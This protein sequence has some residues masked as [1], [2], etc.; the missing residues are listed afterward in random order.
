MAPA[1][2][3]ALADTPEEVG[4]K[5]E[6]GEP[7]PCG[8]IPLPLLVPGLW[9]V[10][11][12]AKYNGEEAPVAGKVVK[13][14]VEGPVTELILCPTGT[15][16]EAL[17]KYLTSVPGAQLRGHLC[18]PECSYLRSNPD[19][20]HLVA[21]QKVLATAEKTWE[22][23]LLVSDELARMREAQAAWDREKEAP[24]PEGEMSSE[25]KEKRNTKKA[26]KKEKKKKLKEQKKKLGG[27]GNAKKD[28]NLLFAGTGL[29][30]DSK[31]RKILMSKVRKKM[32][33]TKESTSSG[34]SSGS[35]ESSEGEIGP[36]MLEDRSNV[37]K[38]AQ[39]GPG[40]LT[41]ES[42]RMMKQ[43]IMQSSGQLWDGSEDS[44]PALASQY[45]RQY[46]NPRASAPMSREIT[47]L[48]YVQDLLLSG[49][50]AE[51]ADVTAQRLKSLELSL[52]GQ[53]WQT[54]QKLELIPAPEASLTSRPEVELALK[55]ARLDAKT[56]PGTSS[57]WGKGQQK[58]KSKESGKGKTTEKGK[59]QAKGDS[60][61]SS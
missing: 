45:A 39:V 32:R 55:E 27:L 49:R 43:F 37:R 24:G 48:A 22:E 7:V 41:A 57:S 8:K 61:K 50:P 40:V 36:Q 46:L 21:L 44:L 17:L 54:S 51:A 31:Q 15:S 29:D 28:L 13:I 20:V 12:H 14:E 52:T 19:L 5:F 56:K 26:K 11:N 59:H 42:V 35:S 10:A 23:N 53:S 3:E 2:P 58:G 33:K 9:V 38:L 1:E 16:S 4:R 60:K 25:E 6:A 30:P 34:S 18:E 47:T